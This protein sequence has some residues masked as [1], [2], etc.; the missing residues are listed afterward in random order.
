M[1]IALNRFCKLHGVKQFMTSAMSGEGISNL[2]SF[3]AQKLMDDSKDEIK[4][5]LKS[6]RI[7]KSKA[8]KKK[9]GCC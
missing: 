9:E 2:F 7:S 5:S 8:G 1:S 3:V 4:D 6:I